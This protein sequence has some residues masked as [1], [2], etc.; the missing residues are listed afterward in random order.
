MTDHAFSRVECED[1]T[2]MKWFMHPL[3]EIIVGATEAEREKLLKVGKRLGGKTKQLVPI[4]SPRTF[5]R[6]VQADAEARAA[7]K[8]NEEAQQVEPTR[9]GN[10]KPE[11]VHDLV[12]EI[13]KETGWGARRIKGELYRHGYRNIARSTINRIL[14][15]NGFG[16]E[17]PG[18]PDNTSANFPRR[19]ASTPWACD[20]FTKPVLTMGG[21]VDFHVPC[22]IHLETQKVYILG[23]TPNPNNEWMKQQARNLCVFF[24]ELDEQPRCIIH[25]AD[26]KFTRDCRE[27]LKAEGD[28]STNDTRL[29]A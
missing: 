23:V 28:L 26:T 27:M 25:D 21:W 5:Q 18:D 13:R 8:D 4:V 19:H 29:P 1:Y 7:K 24:G 10:S 11:E 12:L 20:F 9:H 2:N 17:P 22:F 16:P 3:L 15:E 6:W 14:R